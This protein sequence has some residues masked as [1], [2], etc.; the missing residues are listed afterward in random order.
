MKVI[1]HNR[2]TDSDYSGDPAAEEGRIQSIIEVLRNRSELEFF[3]PEEAKREVIELVHSTE[4]V[5]SIKQ[6]S[7]KLYEMSKLSAG[8]AVTAARAACDGTPTFALI[9]PPGHHASPDSNWGFCYFNNMAIALESL[10]DAGKIEKAFVMDFDLHTGDGNINCLESDRNIKV[11][12]PSGEGR[13]DYMK[14]VENE[15]ETDE[16]YDI[17]GVSAGFDLHVKDWGGKLKTEDYRR[18]GE[19]LKEFSE[20]ACGGRRFALLEGGYNQRVLGKNVLEFIEGFSD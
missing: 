17:L 1:Y 11:L 16:E 4:H 20:R 18:L 6:R 7:K 3:E 9:R 10:K 13:E 19:M 2:F 12:N 5:Q 15:L 8:G 14:K